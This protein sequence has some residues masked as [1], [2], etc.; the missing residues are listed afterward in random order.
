MDVPSRLPDPSPAELAVSAALTER[1]KVAVAAAQGFLPFEA[2]MAE[3]L[4]AP[5]LGYYLNGS[6]KFGA[7]GDFVTAPEISPLFGQAVARQ[8]LQAQA[9]GD[10]IIEFGGGTGKL[11]ASVLTALAGLNALPARYLMLELSPDLRE[12]QRQLLQA[13]PFANELEIDWISDAPTTPAR[14]IIL[15][16]EILDAL[17]TA[18]FERGDA[19]F[20]ERGIGVDDNGALRWQARP[21]GGRLAAALTER[22]AG[23]SLT[24]GYHAEI[25]L[26]Q[27]LW[28]ADLPR[29][30]D[31]G[32]ALLFDYGGPRREIYHP[33]RHD[34][35]LRCYWRHRL[36]ADPLWL[37]GLQDITASVDFTHVAEAAI[38]AGLQ[39]AGYAT[40][41][42]F[43]LANGIE[44]HLQAAMAA[45]PASAM[46]L[47]AQA[48]VLL[49]PSEMGTSFKAMALGIGDVAG[50]TNFALRDERHQL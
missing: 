32:V 10:T 17:P 20:L 23:C 28:V 48:R 24:P 46:R 38:D 37:P 27:S 30:I 35:T 33:D 45:D 25:N 43:L 21:A 15:A 22:L 1:I 8:C 36:H 12:T 5:G 3:A 41:A 18:A 2:F 4:F 44:S 39:L 40:Q 49:L 31:R 9:Y 47:A 16:N 29:F 13:L 19:G 14:G 26:Q 42:S 11:A 50:L 6:R 34:G 7:A